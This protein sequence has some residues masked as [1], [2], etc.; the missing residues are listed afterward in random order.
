[1][2]TICPPQGGF[3]L[4]GLALLAGI[5]GGICA[6]WDQP[7]SE[8]FRVHG[9]PGDLRK[10]VELSE[11]FAHGL[12]AAAILGSVW[13]LAP[14]KRPSLKIAILITVVSGVTANLLKSG[15]V[16][17]R[18]YA[19]HLRVIDSP[20]S[21]ANESSLLNESSSSGKS[22]TWGQEVSAKESSP[23]SG[24]IAESFWDARQRSFPSGHAA[25]AWGLMLG[26]TYV[27]PRGGWLFAV[28]ASLASIQR[29]ESGAHYPTD[30]LAGF[31]IAMLVGAAVYLCLLP[32][33]EP[34]QIRLRDGI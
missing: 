27:F 19:S 15:F 22:S 17:M 24:L 14:E 29:L 13:L 9:L 33:A 28:F 18:P 8:F 34:S 20:D 30:I 26:L 16:R 2:R 4:L 11:V 25:T 3:L 10:A 31:T 6:P 7:L 12:G 32:R 5:V 21:A 1:M 23:D